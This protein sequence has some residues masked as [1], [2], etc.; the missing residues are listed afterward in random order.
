[1]RYCLFKIGIFLILFSLLIPQEDI[2]GE[3]SKEEIF[4]LF[5]LW[6]EI[7]E[8]YVPKQEIVNQLKDVKKE[9]LIEVI[10]GTWCPDSETH[11]CS[12]IKVIDLVSNKKIKVKYFGISRGKTEPEYL[13]KDKNIL[14]VPTFIVYIDGKE[15]GR[16]IETPEKTIE[17]DL[18]NII[19]S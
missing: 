1:M 2:I 5:P 7:S 8:I 3:T 4:D 18:L 15:K 12:F 13:I 11:V 14:K 17:E 16:I 19:I 6:K 10:L 9:I